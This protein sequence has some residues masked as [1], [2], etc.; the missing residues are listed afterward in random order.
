MN[1][2]IGHTL[3]VWSLCLLDDSILASASEDCSMKLWDWDSG[4]C[5]KT[6]LAHSQA[7][8]GIGMDG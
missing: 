5:V 1:T 6:L 4:E 3:P 2:L 7:V 8:W